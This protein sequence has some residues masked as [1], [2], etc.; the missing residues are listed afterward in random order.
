MSKN[1]KLAVLGLLLA[2]KVVKCEGIESI[3]SPDTT[4]IDLA[5]AIIRIQERKP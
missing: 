4:A 5:K 2:E 1:E 3:F